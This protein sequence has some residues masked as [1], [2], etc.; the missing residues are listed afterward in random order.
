M[1]GRGRYGIILFDGV[2]NLCNHAVDFV[3][4]RDSRDRF[5]FASLQEPFLQ[6]FLKK[7][8]IPSAYLDSIVFVHDDRVF[9]KSRAALEIAR[10]MGGFW[11][12]LYVFMLV[13]KI[14][15]DPIYDW[16]ARNR[17]RWYG[18]RSSC[19][20]PEPK[21]ADKFLKPSDLL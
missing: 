3:I 7:R 1:S 19:R 15:R 2:C 20:I 13:P 5:K 21:E 9:V 16:I 18:K 17:Y 6:D 12:L 8:Q 11:K 10:R 14:I 4:R